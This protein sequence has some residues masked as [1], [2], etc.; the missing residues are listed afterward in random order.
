MNQN[1]ELCFEESY[2]ICY[3]EGNTC[4]FDYFD[5]KTIKMKEGFIDE[6]NLKVSKECNFYIEQMLIKDKYDRSR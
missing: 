5:F 4:Y 3:V 2:N 1:V 6:D